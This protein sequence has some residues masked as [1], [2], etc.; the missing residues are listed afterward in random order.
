MK[1]YGS[2][3][4]PLRLPAD[5]QAL[6][7]GMVAL[8]V[9]VACG[10]T[11][12]ILLGGES[13]VA[14]WRSGAG[15][16]AGAPS[17]SSQPADSRLTVSGTGDIIMGG[18]PG[19]LPPEDGRGFFAGVHDALSSDLQMGNLEEPLTEDTGFSKCA[20]PPP[21]PAPA[22]ASGGS[23]ASPSS[24]PLSPS[25]SPALSTTGRPAPQT[26]FAFRV[27]PAYASV[28][29]DG[30]FNLLNLANNHSYDF[31]AEGYRHTVAALESVGLKCTGAPGQITMGD[32]KG[33][34]VAVLGFS[35]FGGTQSLLDI[36][37]AVR[38]VRRAQSQADVVIV[39]MQHGAEGA[40]QT[41]TRPGPETYLDENRGD[42][43]KFAH[44]IVDAGADLVIG[45]GPHVMRGMEF[46]RERL[47]A[48]SLGNFAGYR[49]LAYNGVVGLGGILKVVLGRDG[50]FGGAS[51]IPTHMVAPGLPALDPDRNALP[52]VRS[53]SDTDFPETGAHIGADGA[54]TSR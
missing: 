20:K 35:P 3:L 18:G 9:V 24:F 47:I 7:A 21:P 16:G 33:V 6:V 12:G 38:L 28:L 41:H 23:G 17:T 26:C 19:A 51:L 15:T 50:S 2:R 45:H 53:L 49:S 36:D 42:S 34:R 44:A 31:G 37:G 25:P 5:R 27:P 8:I 30:G 46:Y 10:I 1:T 48:Y 13:G 39:Q 40:D 4:L 54:I 11:A 52:L 43:T 14:S 29:R 22:A 32:V